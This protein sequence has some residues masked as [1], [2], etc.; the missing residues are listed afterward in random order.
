MMYCCNF[1]PWC[2]LPLSSLRDEGGLE[3]KKAIVEAILVVIKAIPESK[4]QGA[5]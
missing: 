3:Y 5:C 2:L 4:E 1:L